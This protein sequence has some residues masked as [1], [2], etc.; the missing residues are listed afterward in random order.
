MQGPPW[1]RLQQPWLLQAP[2]QAM[3]GAGESQLRNPQIS[4][5]PNLSSQSPA[6]AS[7]RPAWSPPAAPRA[8]GAAAWRAAPPRAAGRSARPAAWWPG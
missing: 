6:G 5:A 8:A 1:P 4:A 2:P 7:S 3:H